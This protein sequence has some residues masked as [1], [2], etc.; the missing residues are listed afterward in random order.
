MGRWIYKVFVCGLLVFSSASFASDSDDYLQSARDYLEKNEINAAVIQLKNK[1]KNDPDSIPARALLGEALLANGDPKGAEVE[2]LRAIRLGGDKEKLGLLLARTFLIL[3]KFDEVLAGINLVDNA[4][5]EARAE[6]MVI[7][8]N[9]YLMQGEGDLASNAYRKALELVDGQPS[10]LL[11]QVR[12]HSSKGEFDDALNMVGRVVELDEDNVDAWLLRGELLFQQGND[13]E[14]QVSFSKALAISPNNISSKLGMATVWI[15]RDKLADAQAQI[16]SVLKVSPFHPKAN[17]LNGLLLLQKDDKDGAA[18][19]LSLVQKI[20]P[21]HVLSIYLLGTI[22]YLEKEYQQAESSL[23][24]ALDLAPEHLMARKLLGATYLQLRQPRKTIDI[25]DS[26]RMSYTNDAQ[27]SSL[28][29]AAFMQ[30]GDKEKGAELLEKAVELSP[31]V[32]VMRT[33]LAVGKLALGD[34]DKAIEELQSA[35][36]LDSS[37][38]QAELMLV[39]IYLKESQFDAAIAA[40]KKIIDDKPKDPVGHNLLGTAYMGKGEKS[41]AQDSFK[42]ALLEDDTFNPARINLATL[43]LQDK[44]TQTAKKI[45]EDVLSRDSAHIGAILGMAKIATL[46]N[47]LD[48]VVKWLERAHNTD[49]S[50]VD[51]A[52]MLVDSYLKKEEM[53]KALQVARL[54]AD[55]APNVLLSH[56]IL[57][58]V[59]MAVDEFSNAVSSY[60]R[61]FELSQG[62]IKA[63]ML[64]AGAQMKAGN[65]IAAEKV[66]KNAIKKDSDD[67][68]PYIFLAQLQVSQEDTAQALKTAKMIQKKFKGGSIGYEIQGDIYSHL[69]QFSQALN[70]YRTAFDIEKT[71]TLVLKLYL[72]HGKEGNTGESVKIA[73]GWLKEVPEDVRVRM[74]LAMG[75]QGSGEIKRANEHYEKVLRYQPNN[76]AALNNL[77]WSLAEEGDE[78][79]IIYAKKA[80]ELSSQSPEVMDTYGWVLVQFGQYEKGISVL[81]DASSKAPNLPDLRYHLAYAYYQS[82]NLELARKETKRLKRLG[83]SNENKLEELELLLK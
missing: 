2:L 44:N 7:E 11:G 61:L 46:R 37:L 3:G 59:Y 80:Y 40:A 31:D 22:S 81:R 38:I 65:P 5:V 53:L 30:T 24:K 17:Y 70:S 66:A 9:I 58:R 25:L 48:S 35:V 15:K 34:T 32:A 67:I 52:A 13:D 43:E 49:T 8:G 45:Y 73:E 10:A 79:A 39:Y 4:S 83:Y 56:E 28:L 41:L 57:G 42:Q 76:V 1:L 19:A 20:V 21:E 78:R 82:G 74:M 62:N 50:R 18:A 26:Y 60:K 71:S 29:G 27:F 69:E 51:V 54:T 33:Q 14:A 23:L 47:E 72:S 64:L 12:L 6:L 55:K 36:S 75:L 16:D 77:A 63:A 68:R